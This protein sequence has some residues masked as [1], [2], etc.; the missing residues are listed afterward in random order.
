[1]E[2]LEKPPSLLALYIG[3]SVS[4]RVRVVGRSTFVA[5][6]EEIGW[7]LSLE[8]GSV[9]EKAVVTLRDKLELYQ[10]MLE[11]LVFV[12]ATQMVSGDAFSEITTKCFASCA[13]Q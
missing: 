6:K 1:M 7:K 12:N 10:G 9:G 8:R 2:E 13:K 11:A 5:G 3:D 4:G